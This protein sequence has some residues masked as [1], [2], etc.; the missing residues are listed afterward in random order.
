MKLEP[1][2]TM[3][4]TMTRGSAPATA[5]MPTPAQE[6]ARVDEHGARFVIDAVPG[7]A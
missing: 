7:P 2:L 5:A 1:T 4:K 6:S 3:G